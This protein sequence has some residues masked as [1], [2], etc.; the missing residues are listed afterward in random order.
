MRLGMSE[1][2][3][4]HEFLQIRRDV[5]VERGPFQSDNSARYGAIAAIVEMTYQTEPS[6]LGRDH[7]GWPAHDHIGA[8]KIPRGHQN[9]CILRSRQAADGVIDVLRRNER[10]VRQHGAYAA[11][12]H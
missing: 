11:C 1:T 7:R 10:N 9:H 3:V 6:E 4:T 12:A 5:E 8:G 2:M